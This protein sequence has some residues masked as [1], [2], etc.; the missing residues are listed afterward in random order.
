VCDGVLV[1]RRANPRHRPKMKSGLADE[2]G[3]IQAAQLEDEIVP[4]K[5]WGALSQ[6]LDK[7][8]EHVLQGRRRGRLPGVEQQQVRSFFSALVQRSEGLEQQV[9]AHGSENTRRSPKPS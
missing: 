7:H 5:L 9:D 3:P 1:E 4:G 8:T 2:T 6:P